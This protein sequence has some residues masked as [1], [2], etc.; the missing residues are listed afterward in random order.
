MRKEVVLCFIKINGKYL[1]F[2]RSS[3]VSYFHHLWSQIA[4]SLKNGEDPKARASLELEEEANIN[5][6]KILS[7]NK[8]SVY[9]QK[10]KLNNVLW[11]RHVFMV[12]IKKDTE[13]KIDWEHD[14]FNLFSYE[15]AVKLEMPPQTKQIFKRIISLSSF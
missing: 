2:K 13:I 11:I 12:E 9:E 1:F 8:I 10:D 6:D 4:G 14:S 15:E 3:K 5:P 7:L